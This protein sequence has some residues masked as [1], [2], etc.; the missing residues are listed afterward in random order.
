[1]GS[2]NFY[3]ISGQFIGVLHIHVHRYSQMDALQQESHSQRNIFN[4]IECLN[5]DLQA[6]RISSLD[7]RETHKNTD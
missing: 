1:M 4:Y 6:E 3:P 5:F 7:I 2:H